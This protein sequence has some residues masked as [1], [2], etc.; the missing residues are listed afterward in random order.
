MA[1][2]DTFLGIAPDDGIDTDSTDSPDDVSMVE[3]ETEPVV[4]PLDIEFD[5]NYDHIAVEEKALKVY[6]EFHCLLME[7]AALINKKKKGQGGGCRERQ[8]NVTPFSTTF[9]REI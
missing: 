7:K 9:W 5:P 2:Q 8:E 1:H 6:A 3:D 4:P